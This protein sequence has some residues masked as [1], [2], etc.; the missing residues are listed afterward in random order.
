MSPAVILGLEFRGFLALLA[1]TFAYRMLTGRLSLAGLFADKTRNQPVSPE[2]VQLLI[3][4]IAVS[5]RIVGQAAHGST[6]FPTV[7]TQ[8]LVV[9]GA[10]SGVYMSVKAA[11]MWLLKTI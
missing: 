7:S 5:A 8:E 10:S 9:F 2:R 3:S 11:K 4:T 6:V 1:A